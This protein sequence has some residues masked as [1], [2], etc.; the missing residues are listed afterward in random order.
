MKFRFVFWKV[1]TCKRIVDRRFRGA[2]CLL[3]HQIVLLTLINP[4]KQT[5]SGKTNSALSGLRNPTN[6]MGHEGSLPHSQKPAI[7]PYTELD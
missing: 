6:F 7:G 4:G 2:C 1:L 5:P 3:H